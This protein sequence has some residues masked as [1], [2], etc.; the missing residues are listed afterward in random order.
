MNLRPYQIEAIASV[1]KE[2]AAGVQRTAVVLPCGMG[3]TV[4]F[5]ELCRIMA[6]QSPRRPLVLVNRDELVRQTVAKLKACDSEMRI[7]VVQGDRNDLYDVDVVVASVQTISRQ[8]RLDRIPTNRFDLIVAD[9]FHYS[10]S[11]S[12]QRVLHHFGALAP[13]SPTLAVGFSATPSRSDRL[14]LGDTWQ[15]VSYQLG[16]DFGIENGF[17]SPVE[18]AT[19]SVPDLDL[20]KVKQSRGDFADGALAEAMEFSHAPDRVAEAYLREAMGEDGEP[21]RG[22]LFAPTVDSARAFADAFNANGI[23]TEVVVGSTPPVER[24]AAYARVVEGETRVLASVAVLSV[25]FDLPCIEVAV[26]ARPTKSRALYVQQAGRVMRL[27]PETGKE[28]ALILDVVGATALGL[29]S[30]VDLQP[31]REAGPSRE[32]GAGGPAM[33]AKPKTTLHGSLD[34]RPID[35]ITGAPLGEIKKRKKGTV[36]P[37]HRTATGVP[38]IGP[39]STFPGLLFATVGEDG[40]RGWYSRSGGGH[41]EVVFSAPDIASVLL[42]LQGMHPGISEL[43]GLEPATVAQKAQLRRYGMEPH[44][45]MTKR[46]ASDAIGAAKASRLLDPLVPGGRHK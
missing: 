38:F 46:Q 14:G 29:A 30:F 17:L 6:G 11:P 18:A 45:R 33:P 43:W 39:T 19:A 44:E 7:G 24:Q 41:A 8:S 25:G 22:I 4:V 20:A 12:W 34:L 5:A 31:T 36:S 15:T 3:K 1:L 23:R 13:S 21:R 32:V 28:S 26:M 2:W 9:E 40:A 16:I 10:A 42:D 37:I 27:S 35:P